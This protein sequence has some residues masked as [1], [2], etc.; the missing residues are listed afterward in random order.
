M[1]YE[2]IHIITSFDEMKRK[3]NKAVENVG[4]TYM[5]TFLFF[6]TRGRVPIYDRFVNRAL[7]ALLEDMIPG[8]EVGDLGTCVFDTSNCTKL[9]NNYQEL[10]EKALD[11]TGRRLSIIDNKHF[12]ENSV[13]DMKAIK[14][15]RSLDRALWVY[16][17]K[18][19]HK[20]VHEITSEK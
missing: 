12:S 9:F 16:G 10:I 11:G 19:K 18:F 13:P 8:T 6:K 5:L 7:N 2:R 15:V 14:A 17:H 20:N 4:S 3:N 1:I